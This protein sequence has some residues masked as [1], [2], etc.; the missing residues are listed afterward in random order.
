MIG[1]YNSGIVNLVNKIASFAGVKTRLDPIEKFATGGIFP[2]YTPGRDVGLA[3]VSGGEAIMRPEFTKAV[4]ADFVHAANRHRPH[5]G[6]GCGAGLA[7]AGRSNSA[8]R[9]WRSRAA[10][11]CPASRAS[12]GSAGSCRASWGPEEVRPRR[13]GE[14]LKSALGKILGGHVPGSGL[15]RDVIAEDP[16]VDRGPSAD[17]R[18]VQVEG[19][20]GQWRRPDRREGLRERPELGEEPERQAVRL[21]RRR[22]GR[23][24]LL[25]LHVRDHERDPR[26]VAVLAPVLDA[27]SFGASGGPGGFVRNANSAFRVGVT[28]T[29]ASATWPER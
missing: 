17:L 3:A 12:S 6:P 8:A 11:S 22:A 27:V 19:R 20:P 13:A 16:E 29:L 21:G 26:Q 28:R 5:P 15:F 4:G 18:L 23:L 7:D 24:R 1:L 14:G 25:G 10:A 9:A 2:G